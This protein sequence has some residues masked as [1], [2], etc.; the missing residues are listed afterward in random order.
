[1]VE[2]SFTEERCRLCGAELSEEAYAC[3]RCGVRLRLGPPPRVRDSRYLRRFETPGVLV[4]L[5][6]AIASQFLGSVVWTVF[7]ILAFLSFYRTLTALR[8]RVFD[9]ENELTRAAPARAKRRATA[10]VGAGEDR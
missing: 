6:L 3:S 10:D 5:A 9:L 7:T 2:T 8:R 1:V 4:L